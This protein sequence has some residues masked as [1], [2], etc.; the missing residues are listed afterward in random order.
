MQAPG[1]KKTKTAR[2]W[3]YVRDEQPWTGQSPPCAWYLFT[4]DRK[5]EHPVSHLAGYK[6]WAHAV[7]YAGFDGLFGDDKAHEMASMAHVQRKFVEVFTSQCSAIAKDAIRRIADLYALEKEARRKSPEKRVAVRQAGV[8]SIIDDLEARLHAQLPKISGKS[9]LAQTI[10]YAPG[11]M[12]QARPCLENGHLELHDNTA[13]H[14]VK[15][16][17]IGRKNWMFAGSQGGKAMAFILIETAKLYD[18]NPKVW[19]TWVLAQIA[20]HKITRIDE[21]LWRYAAIA[22]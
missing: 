12:Q 15:P 1:Q 5:G 14:A 7:G 19:L 3:A 21:L 10:R 8:R 6:S 2:V 16:V 11:R 13:E 18:V 9:P 4:I 20:D 22:A 17:A